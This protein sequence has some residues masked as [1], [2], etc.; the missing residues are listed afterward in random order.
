MFHNFR[1]L[2]EYNTDT[3]S[4]PGI[5]PYPIVFSPPMESS[6]LPIELCEAVMN[7]LPNGYEFG[8]PLGSWGVLGYRETVDG[9]RA[10]C[11][12]ALTC[13][14]WRV[15]AQYILSIFPRIRDDAHLAHFTTTVQESPITGLTL[16]HHSIESEYL[17]A[18]KAS[19]LFMHSCV[20]LQHFRC[21]RVHFDHGPPLRLLRMRLPFFASIT[22]LQ[23]W[24][25]TFQSFRAM[26]DVV[27]ACPNLATLGIDGTEFKAKA[28]P[29]AGIRQM[30]AVV[31]HLRA[32]QKITSLYLDMYSLLA[33]SH[34]LPFI[35][36][37]FMTYSLYREPGAPPVQD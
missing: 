16:G 23:L 29:A 27:W 13:R 20:H 22:T 9:Q 26:M 8:P 25:C 34:V 35:L 11:A 37:P 32:C 5:L 33:S 1:R 31:E 21:I 30:S 28:P 19:E 12:C 14:A 18:S 10:L 7:A 3:K 4:I 15:R 6:R 24:S 2:I 17:D 36:R